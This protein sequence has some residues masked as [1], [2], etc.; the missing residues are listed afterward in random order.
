MSETLKQKFKCPVIANAV[1][2][3]FLDTEHGEAVI[4][5]MA[6]SISPPK[7]LAM[8]AETLFL[9]KVPESP[10]C[11]E[12][13]RRALKHLYAEGKIPEDI[14]RLSDPHEKFKDGPV[15][16]NNHLKYHDRPYPRTCARCGLRPCPFA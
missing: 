1:Y 4:N 9:Y 14:T 12:A 2:K 11:S 3:A 15:N 6:E 5:A 8:A 13:I 7:L 10:E 16:C